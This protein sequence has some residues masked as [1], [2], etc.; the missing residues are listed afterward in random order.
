M[1]YSSKTLYGSF[2]EPVTFKQGNEKLI[3]YMDTVKFKM[4]VITSQHGD[5][6][7]PT[8]NKDSMIA[9]PPENIMS[10]NNLQ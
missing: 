7:I 4:D 1:I 10:K 2:R 9:M 8:P 3:D 6:W 5:N